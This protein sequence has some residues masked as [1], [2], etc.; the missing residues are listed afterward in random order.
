VKLLLDTHILIRASAGTLP[1]EAVSFIAGPGNTLLFSPASIWEIVI[2]KGLG[3]ADFTI[4]PFALYRGLLERGYIELAITSRHVLT[5][6][7]L[8]PLHK[9]PFDRLLVAQARAEDITLLTADAIVAQYE[10]AI[11]HLR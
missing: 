4:D 9:D 1:G 11:I 7:E 5:V 3:R 10:G 2:K 8:P 6:G